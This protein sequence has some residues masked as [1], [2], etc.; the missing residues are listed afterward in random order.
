MSYDK[1]LKLEEQYRKKKEIDM[2]WSELQNE[3]EEQKKVY[4][5]DKNSEFISLAKGTWVAVGENRLLGTYKD[6][7]EAE[8]CGVK[9]LKNGK[10]VFITKVGY[11]EEVM[12]K[13]ESEIGYLAIKYQ[14]FVLTRQQ[15]MRMF[16]TQF[17]SAKTQKKTSFSIDFFDNDKNEIMGWAKEWCEGMS[18]RSWRCNWRYVPSI[19]IGKQAYI[20]WILKNKEN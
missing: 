13:N 6:Q 7:N 15:I 5:T 4:F 14:K 18:S 2:V 3:L 10:V 12:K 20:E 9:E 11:E 8:H 16:D 17:M 1:N 19:E